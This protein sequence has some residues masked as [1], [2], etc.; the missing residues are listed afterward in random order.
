MTSAGPRCA[1]APRILLFSP[2]Q[3]HFQ[4]NI[5]RASSSAAAHA[6]TGRQTACDTA[7]K[8]LDTKAT[9]KHSQVS[10]EA[11]RRA[12]LVQKLATLSRKR[13]DF[14]SRMNPQIN[15]ADTSRVPEAKHGH[16]EQQ[17]EGARQTQ[18]PSSPNY[19]SSG[20]GSTTVNTGRT[21]VATSP[22]WHECVSAMNVFAQLSS[23]CA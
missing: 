11:T 1:G 23:K 9:L 14:A 15:R 20:S 19:S 7:S 3:P 13:H 4:F 21:T 2:S 22:A 6:Q 16:R 17:S 5:I 10:H 8:W 18:S 12:N